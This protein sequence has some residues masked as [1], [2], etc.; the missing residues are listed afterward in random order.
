MC[1]R[2]RVC[3]FQATI[4]GTLARRPG[5]SKRAVLQGAVMR[6]A[7][8]RETALQCG[9]SSGLLRVCDLHTC[10]FLVIIRH[11]AYFAVTFKSSK[12]VTE[13]AF[14]HSPILPASLKVSS[15]ASTFLVPS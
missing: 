5:C 14:V 7:M 3:G 15:V 12:Y 11:G 10:F 6:G 1:I 4:Q 9:I 8:S 2:D 13:S